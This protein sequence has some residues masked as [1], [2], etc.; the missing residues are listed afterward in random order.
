MSPAGVVRCLPDTLLGYNDFIIFIVPCYMNGTSREGCPPG[1][2]VRSRG[3]RDRLRIGRLRGQDR[4]RPRR[5]SLS[6][7]PEAR[8]GRLTVLVV[9]LPAGGQVR[10]RDANGTLLL[11]RGVR[12]AEEGTVDT[13]VKHGIRS[14]RGCVRCQPDTLLGYNDISIFI[15]PYIMNR[16]EGVSPPPFRPRTFPVRH[17]RCSC[18]CGLRAPALRR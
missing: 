14:S 18:P 3:R 10:Q 9:E 7:R 12:V 5:E 6:H 4:E 2:P 11:E 17:L 13:H 15:V 8:E 1:C 16:R